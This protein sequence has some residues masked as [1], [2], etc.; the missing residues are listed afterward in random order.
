MARLSDDAHHVLSEWHR[1][2][3]LAGAA[4]ARAAEAET[5]APAAVHAARLAAALGD[6]LADLAAAELRAAPVAVL[7]HW[8]G[9]GAPRPECGCEDGPGNAEPCPCAAERAQAADAE[10]A[11]PALS[12]IEGGSR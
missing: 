12:L 1:F 4:S 3:A 8:C 11:R 7:C 10:G 9:H 2:A 6:V 5:G